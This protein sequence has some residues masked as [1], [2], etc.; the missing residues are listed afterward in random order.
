M[1][2]S[3]WGIGALSKLASLKYSYKTRRYFKDLRFL[4]Q[5]LSYILSVNV[6]HFLIRVS[7]NVTS[8]CSRLLLLSLL[9]AE[10]LGIVFCHFFFSRVVEQAEG[11][12]MGAVEASVWY[13]GFHKQTPFTLCAKNRMKQS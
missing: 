13:A 9:A 10:A 3:G 12:E 11:V 2:T 4:K 1:C 7:L 8:K 5:N 6:A